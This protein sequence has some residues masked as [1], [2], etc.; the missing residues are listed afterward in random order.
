MA[1]P[2]EFQVLRGILRVQRRIGI[3]PTWYLAPLSL[4]LIAATFEGVS[5]GLLVPMVN[6]FVTKDFSFIRSITGLRHMLALLPAQMTTTDQSLFLVLLGIFAI[7]VLLKNVFR[8]MANLGMTYVGLRSIHH[9]RKTLFDRYLMFGKM[10]FD[11][12]NLGHDAAVLSQFAKNTIRPLLICDK[13]VN[14]FFSLLVSLVVMTLLSWPLTF[15]ALPL[16]VLLHFSIQGIIN[17]M[18]VISR[19]LTK[20]ASDLEKQTVEILSAAPFVQSFNMQ[21][22]EKV[23]HARISDESA[24]LSYRITAVQSMIPPLHEIITLTAAMLLFGIMMFLLVRQGQ[25]TAPSFLVYFY[26]I[27]NAAGKFSTVSNFRGTVAEARGSLEQIQGILQDEGKHFVPEGTE[28]FDGLHRDIRFEH[29]RFSYGHGKDVLRDL[30]FIIH[31]G[32]VTAI[33]G[34]TGAG[35][36]TLIHLLLRHYDCPPG[37]ILLDGRDIR[38]FTHAS[39]RRRIALVSQETFLIHDTIRN[40]VTYGLTGK[41][42]DD[43]RDVLEKARLWQFVERLPQ[44]LDTL[45]GDRG[46]KLSGGEKQRLSIARA[47]LKGADILILDEATSALDSVTEGLVQE[48]IDEAMRG[49]TA[50]VIAHRLS[51]IQHADT[52]VVMEKG[53]L[54]EQGSLQELLDRKGLFH[55]FWE[56]QKFF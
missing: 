15:F 29:L 40:N 11:Q 5:V 19:S 2:K 18:H 30:S 24:R 44:G 26:L 25:G 46:V 35:K 51:T 22:E 32:T 17:R 13:Y 50:I 52:I 37:S 31:K 43:V 39:L 3:H 34:A 8:Y 27:L 1:F 54:A 42:D 47:M 9:L 6:G 49:K 53:L 55:G 20:T 23:E 38:S 28:E 36:T 10:F 45:I 16:F 14:A 56:Q 21:E 4:S 7:C 33:V 12:T 48:A 41:T